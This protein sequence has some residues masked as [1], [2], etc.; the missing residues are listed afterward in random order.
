MR[1]TYLPYDTSR[2]NGKELD[3]KP[4]IP[5]NNCARRAFRH[6]VSERQPWIDGNPSPSTWSCPYFIDME[7]SDS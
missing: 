1:R 2:C 3:E 5:C 4:V 7:I 6:Q